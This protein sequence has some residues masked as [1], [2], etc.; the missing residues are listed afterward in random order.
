MLIK[1]I[2]I[3][4]INETLRLSIN[5]LN[6]NIV[7]YIIYALLFFFF[8]TIKFQKETLPIE[9]IKTHIYIFLNLKLVC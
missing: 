7:Q 1:L 2:K 4:T 9:S 5:S 3:I 6:L 8:F